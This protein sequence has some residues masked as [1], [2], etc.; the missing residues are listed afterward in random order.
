MSVDVL[1]PN[2]D[3]HCSDHQ[4]KWAPP[5]IRRLPM[6]TQWD[7]WESTGGQSRPSRL[8]EGAALDRPPSGA[9]AVGAQAP[10]RDGVHIVRPRSHRSVADAAPLR[11][12]GGGGHPFDF[13]GEG[14]NGNILCKHMCVCVSITFVTYTYVWRSGNL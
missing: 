3:P 4:W 6:I 5:P 1:F 11:S 13:A 12:T 2:R 10:R 8:P 7:A 9:D 14:G